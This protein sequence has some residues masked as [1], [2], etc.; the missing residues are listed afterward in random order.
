M[1]LY[2]SDVAELTQFIQYDSLVYAWIFLLQ[3]LNKR[4]FII[5]L[6]FILCLFNVAA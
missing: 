3:Y 4:I 1:I 5:F 6:L 2:V